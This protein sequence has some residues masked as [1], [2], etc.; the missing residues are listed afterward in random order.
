M[1]AATATR[2]CSAPPGS[3]GYTI[4]IW[5]GRHIAEPTELAA[6]EASGYWLEVRQVASA[7]QRH[8]R[9]VKMNYQTLGNA[10]PHLHAHLLPRFAQDPVPGRPL[11]FPEGERPRL[12][13]ETF[14]GMLVPCAP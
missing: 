5:R 4:V 13:E 1:P 8:Y 3:L 14:A 2:I 11:P 7:L 6:Q 9:P 10:V 12:P